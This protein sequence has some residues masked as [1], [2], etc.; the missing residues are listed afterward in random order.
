MGRMTTTT[1]GLVL[2]GTGATATAAVQ[3][4]LQHRLC[5]LP[6]VSPPVEIAV[7]AATGIGLNAETLPLAAMDSFED[8]G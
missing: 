6:V 7:G 1:F 8:C 4:R 5:H 2:Q 3:A